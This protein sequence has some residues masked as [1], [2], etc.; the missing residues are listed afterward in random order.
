VAATVVTGEEA[1]VAAV[2]VRLRVW[3]AALHVEAD[4]PLPA[5]RPPEKMEGLGRGRRCSQGTVPSAVGH[6][7][8]GWG[9]GGGGGCGGEGAGSGSGGGVDLARVSAARAYYIP[10]S[11]WT[12]GRLAIMPVCF[13]QICIARISNRLGW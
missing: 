9:T 3:R 5:R 2:V 11:P 8:L 13:L 7:D 6:R 4:N 10:S 1:L 12:A